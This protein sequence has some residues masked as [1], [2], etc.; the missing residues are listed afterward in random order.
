[1]YRQIIYL[2]EKKK[3]FTIDEILPDK[4]MY[5]YQQKILDAIEITTTQKKQITGII[6]K[7]KNNYKLYNRQEL[8]MICKKSK[9]ILPEPVFKQVKLKIDNSLKTYDDELLLDVIE[10]LEALCAKSPA[11]APS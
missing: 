9:Q 3:N 10:L 4:Q 7:L 8:Q 11:E 6:E 5:D 1:L 2:L